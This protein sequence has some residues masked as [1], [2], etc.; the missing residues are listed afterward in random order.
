MKVSKL[1]HAIVVVGAAV[2]GCAGDDDARDVDA[3]GVAD[4]GGE[5]AGMLADAGAAVDAGMS[6]AGEEEDAF[7]LIL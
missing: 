7:V 5:D 3:G 1:F 4:A 2:T 6:D